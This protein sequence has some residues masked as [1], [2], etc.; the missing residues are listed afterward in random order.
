KPAD[1]F[2]LLFF[3][4]AFAIVAA[5]YIVRSPGSAGV[6]DLARGL[7]RFDPKVPVSGLFGLGLVLASALVAYIPFT[8]MAHF[9]AKYFTYHAVR[10]DDRRNERGSAIEGQVAASLGCRP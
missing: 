10:W 8:H 2:N 4:I 7:L 9:I 1:F 6:G 5:G 3:I